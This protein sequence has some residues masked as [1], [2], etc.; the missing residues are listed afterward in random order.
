MENRRHSS[1]WTMPWSC[2]LMLALSIW[3]SMRA[4]MVASISGFG[5]LLALSM[6]SVV[7]GIDSSLLVG[8]GF[9]E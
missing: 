6:D 4:V 7:Q 3:R 1:M 9:T 2:F 8:K 5:V